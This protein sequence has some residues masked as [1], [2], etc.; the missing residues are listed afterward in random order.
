V[1]LDRS[2]ADQ[3]F[4][5]GFTQGAWVDGEF[6]KGLRYELFVGNG[7]D[8]LTIPTTKIDRRPVYS[9]SAWWE[10]L[11]VYGIP[12]RARGMYDDYQNHNKPIIR[13]G[14]SYTKSKENRFSN[15]DQDRKP[16]KTALFNSD[17]VN[18]FASGAFAPGVTVNDATYRML[19]TDGGV[20]WRGLAV[21]AQSFFDG[22]TDSAP[23]VRSPSGRHSITDSSWKS[24]SSSFLRFVVPK[25]W[26]LYGRTSFVFGQ[27]RNSYEYAPVSSG[28]SSGTI[29]Y[30]W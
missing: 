11:G 12:G 9:G 2:I 19:A 7:L 25:K 22:S 5:P 17:R 29:A 18:T 6:W 21:N 1:Q 16:E 24:A 26:E 13:F 27:F 4:R 20:K 14:A 8:I 23:T 3:F 10:P 15:L 28:I 30:S